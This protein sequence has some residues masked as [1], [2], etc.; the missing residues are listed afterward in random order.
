MSVGFRRDAS[1]R[2]AFFKNIELPRMGTSNAA[3]PMN[4]ALKAAIGTHLR[5]LVCES[6]VFADSQPV[7]VEDLWVYVVGHREDIVGVLVLLGCRRAMRFTW[8]GNRSWPTRHSSRPF[9]LGLIT[10]DLLTLAGIS[11]TTS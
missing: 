11:Q 7:L 6:S 4:S 3:E 9:L 2:S 8:R 10:L 1:I 5:P